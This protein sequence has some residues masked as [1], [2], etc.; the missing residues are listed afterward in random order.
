MKNR[1]TIETKKVRFETAPELYGLFFEDI[2]R[3]ADGGLYP[4]CIRNRSF[5]DSLVPEGCTSDKNHVI[6]LNDGKWPGAFNH[7]EGMDEW[8][9]AV[10]YTEIPA[11]YPVRASMKLMTGDTLNPR[12]KAA[13]RVRFEEGGSIENIGYCG[14]SAREGESYSVLFFA[15]CEKMSVLTWKLVGKDGKVLGRTEIPVETEPQV[16]YVK[17]TGRITSDGTDHE[18]R[19]VI[20]ADRETE[21]LFGFTSMLP[22]KTFMGHGLREDLAM[23]LKNTHGKFIRFP[24]GCVVEGINEE[25][26]LRF[27]HTVGPIWERPSAQ[28]MWHYRTTNGLGFHEYLQLCED[29]EME[30]LY[31]LNCGISCQARHGHGF[32]E[33]VTDGYLQEALWAMEYEIGRAHV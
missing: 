15:K 3:A 6:Y 13:L 12:R 30:A 7:G 21:I 17:Y 22:E 10:P 31:V 25:N 28:L 19:L 2:N 14:I 29:L 16:G 20:E 24:G 33:E 9:A 27:S 23:A 4:E 5:E 32:P 18:S 8:A 11:W 1:I 26:T